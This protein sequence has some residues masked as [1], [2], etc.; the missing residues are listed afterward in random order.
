MIHQAVHRRSDTPETI[1]ALKV[2][3][4]RAA[5]S[6]KVFIDLGLALISCRDQDSLGK[7]K[8]G[9]EMVARGFVFLVGCSA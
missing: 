5:V 2:C 7:T 1:E 9:C 3:L 8:I 4:S 6:Y